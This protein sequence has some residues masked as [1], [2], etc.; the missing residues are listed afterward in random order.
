MI[1]KVPPTGIE[2]VEIRIQ[3]NLAKLVSLIINTYFF[4]FLND[5]PINLPKNLPISLYF[6]VL[7]GYQV[8]TARMVSETKSFGK[9]NE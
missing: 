5:L 4:G 9:E 8:T 2:P 1:F 3:S 7:S 6:A